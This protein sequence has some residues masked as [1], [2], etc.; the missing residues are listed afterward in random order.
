M[1]YRIA[2]ENLMIIYIIASF[3]EFSPF[4]CKCKFNSCNHICEKGCEVIEA[5][6]KGKICS[7]RYN[8]YVSIYN[9][10]KDIKEWDVKQ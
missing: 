5:V 4:M 9:E 8:S 2:L 3:K 6:N 10:I 1:N 7:S